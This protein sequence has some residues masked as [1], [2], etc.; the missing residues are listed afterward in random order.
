MT[1]QLGDFGLSHGGGL[2]GWLVRLGTF[3]RYGHACVVVNTAPLEIVEAAG[4]GARRRGCD[5]GEFVWSRCP[6]T[7]G[8]RTD[9]ADEA[10]RCI[11]L[12]YGWGDIALFVVRF[13]GAKIRQHSADHADQRLVCSELVAWCYRHAG[14]EVAPSPDI[15]V[16]DVSPGDLSDHIIREAS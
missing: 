14:H 12:P 1:V 9:I 5:P 2:A 15:A 6:L 4:H 13:F 16:G 10:V 11:G 3:S 7:L 8:Q